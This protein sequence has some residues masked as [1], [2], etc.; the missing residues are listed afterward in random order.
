M[1]TGQDNPPFCPDLPESVNLAL[2]LLRDVPLNFYSEFID[3]WYGASFCYQSRI[4]AQMALEIAPL[5]KT[6]A[7]AYYE[8]AQLQVLIC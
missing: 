1:L 8:L 4:Y 7:V 6:L 5:S 3:S 2:Q